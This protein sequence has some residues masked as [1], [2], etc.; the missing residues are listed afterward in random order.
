MALT[1]IIGSGIGTV[2]NQFADSNM[3]AGSIIQAVDTSDATQTT[4][5]NTT[6]TDTGLTLSITPQS[7]SSKILV[8]CSQDVQVWNTSNYATGRWRI[9]RNIGGG[10]F[11]A[12]YQDSSAGNGN[13][14]AYDYGGSGINIYMPISMTLID[15]PSTTSACIYKTQVCQGTN[16]GNRVV[17]NNA[18]PARIVLMEIAG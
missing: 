13:F 8:T 5:Q 4:V 3:S 18:S 16:G 1:K 2:T 11:S 17:A 14:F 6:F 7:T 9:M 15:Q 12:I 10:S